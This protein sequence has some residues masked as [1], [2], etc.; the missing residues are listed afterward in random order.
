[1]EGCMV[2]HDHRT[3]LRSSGSNAE[4]TYFC[5]L[6]PTITSPTT[7][8]NTVI[9][10]KL[11][12]IC[13]CM[14][15]LK[16]ADVI[17]QTCDWEKTWDMHGDDSRTCRLRNSCLRRERRGGCRPSGHC[18]IYTILRVHAKV[19]RLDSFFDA[20]MHIFLAILRSLDPRAR[21]K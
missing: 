15:E 4:H 1:M 16:R 11:G 6:V 14:Q 19:P 18:R 3:T 2:H 8:S 17:M 20:C 10:H 21:L 12:Y 5:M 13:M 9:Y 7:L